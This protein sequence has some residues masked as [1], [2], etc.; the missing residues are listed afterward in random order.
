[1]RR[2]TAFAVLDGHGGDAVDF[3][4]IHGRGQLQFMAGE[5]HAPHGSAGIRFQRAVGNCLLARFVDT[6][7]NAIALLRILAG[8]VNAFDLHE[9][10]QAWAIGVLGDISRRPQAF[11]HDRNPSC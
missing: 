6:A 11:V 10:E 5:R 2:G 8:H 3:D 7:V 4:Q 1:M 9:V